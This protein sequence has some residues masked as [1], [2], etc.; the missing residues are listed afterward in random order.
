M[1]NDTVTVTDDT[2]TTDAGVFT[3]AE[4]VIL[5][6][7]DVSGLPEDMASALSKA[8]AP[9]RRSSRKDATLEAA[10]HAAAWVLGQKDIPTY[11]NILLAV[12]SLSKALLAWDL[13][14]VGGPGGLSGD[15][16]DRAHWARNLGSGRWQA[17]DGAAYR[18]AAVAAYENLLS[19]DVIRS[20]APH[21]IFDEGEL[22]AMGVGNFR[23]AVCRDKL[24]EVLGNRHAEAL[25][26]RLALGAN[27]PDVDIPGASLGRPVGPDRAK[28][29]EMCWAGDTHSARAFALEL[30]MDIHPAA[31]EPEEAPEATS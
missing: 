30:W 1:N 17:T 27:D 21:L 29:P 11:G 20:E 8:G 14:G 31:P 6:R 2:V 7:P 22:W 15:A 10:A 9:T 16:T 19:D 25:S 5:R 12:Q 26:L 4:V 13:M 3:P 28:T 24:R 18:E 23:V